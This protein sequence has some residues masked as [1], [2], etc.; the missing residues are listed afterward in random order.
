MKSECCKE[1]ANSSVAF[2][3]TSPVALLYAYDVGVVSS[4]SRRFAATAGIFIIDRK[5]LGRILLV[6]SSSQ[7]LI[8]SPLHVSALNLTPAVLALQPL[9]SETLSFQLS[10]RE[11]DLVP[12]L[13][14]F[15]VTLR[16]TFASSPHISRTSDST[17]GERIVLQILGA[18][19]ADCG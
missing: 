19:T 18:A 7:P 10:I 1:W 11:N 3:R 9:K 17:F 15:I 4:T 2:R 14:H 6:L 8:C 13:T 5:R 12:V 16:P